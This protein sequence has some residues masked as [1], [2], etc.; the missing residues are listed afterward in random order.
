MSVP[1]SVR[2]V[3]RPKN[4]V[5]IDTGSNG[6]HRYVVRERNGS[7]CLKGRNPM[8]RNGKTIGHIINLKFVPKKQDVEKLTLDKPEWLSYGASALVY[9]LGHD[10]SCETTS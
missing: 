7:I 10:I 1:E 2:Q 5:V 4:T 8:P 3:I 6:I 9:S